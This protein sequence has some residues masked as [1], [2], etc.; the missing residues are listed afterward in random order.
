NKL[1]YP[2]FR[3]IF[4]ILVGVE[5]DSGV[6]K[7]IQRRGSGGF[8]E[9]IVGIA[10]DEVLK[11]AI[12]TIDITRLVIAHVRDVYAAIR[13]DGNSPQIAYAPIGTSRVG[14]IRVIRG[15]D[16]FGSA[17]LNIVYRHTY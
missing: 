6:G 7:R 4:V 8:H 9:P 12:D 14:V 11:S 10:S 2:T 17:S 16:S 15:I 13:G 1:R 3:I 5:S